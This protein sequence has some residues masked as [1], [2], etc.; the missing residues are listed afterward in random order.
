M[1]LLRALRRRRGG[2]DRR[3]NAARLCT[4]AG[5]DPLDA[6]VRR[7]TQAICKLR[8]MMLNVADADDLML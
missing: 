1:L 2:G 3:L 8:R 4:A 7:S 6:D 5:S